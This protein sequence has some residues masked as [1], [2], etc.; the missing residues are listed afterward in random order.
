ML[1]AHKEGR[2]GKF[3]R[4]SEPSP[5]AGQTLKRGLAK[6]LWR[7]AAL[8][9]GSARGRGASGLMEQLQLHRP[10][11]KGAAGL[12]LK[13]PGC[14]GG[15]SGGSRRKRAGRPGG[16]RGGEGSP[17]PGGGGRGASQSLLTQPRRF[18]A[19]RAGR[20]PNSL[21]KKGE[22]EKRKPVNNNNNPSPLVRGAF[23][24]AP[25]V[26][27]SENSP[28]WGGPTAKGSEERPEAG[29]ECWGRGGGMGWGPGPH[30][31]CNNWFR[32]NCPSIWKR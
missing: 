1:R 8:R 27:P 32:D 4:T 7:R 10:T 29:L 22:R 15:R 25:A 24:S 14:P 11:S 18:L 20:R 21:V 31:L 19:A 23:T 16:V 17:G 13:S 30:Q 12:S 5:S 3:T 26:T 9:S 6:S 2:L 28:D